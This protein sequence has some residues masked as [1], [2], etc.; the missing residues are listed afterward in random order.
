MQSLRGMPG[1]SGLTGVVV[2]W[3]Q[4]FLY[5]TEALGYDLCLKSTLQAA[6]EPPDMLMLT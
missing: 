5:I 2:S 6:G 1:R 3:R 4:V